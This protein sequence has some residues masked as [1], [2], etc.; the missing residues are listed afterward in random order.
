[1][2]SFLHGSLALLIPVTVR[3]LASMVMTVVLHLT[4]ARVLDWLINQLFEP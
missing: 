4:S 1:M 3:L 2:A